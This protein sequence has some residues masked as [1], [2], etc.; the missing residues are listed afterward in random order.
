MRKAKAMERAQAA[1]HRRL[2]VWRVLHKRRCIRL[3]I[4][5][6]RSATLD[7]KAGARL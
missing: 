6:K 7:R 5:A 3:A 1:L 2:R 4:G